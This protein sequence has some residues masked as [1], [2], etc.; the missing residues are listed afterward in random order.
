MK[1]AKTWL[2]KVLEIVSSRLN[3]E[4]LEHVSTTV[5][6]NRSESVMQRPA[7]EAVSKLFPTEDRDGGVTRIINLLDE[8]LSEEPGFKLPYVTPT[9]G[10][11]LKIKTFSVASL[12]MRRK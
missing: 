9:L 1:L 3:R 11:R 10:T 5:R 8:N 7:K 4:P 6:W 12:R 2:K